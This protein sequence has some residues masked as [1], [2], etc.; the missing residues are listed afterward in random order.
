MITKI[1][2]ILFF[3]FLLSSNYLSAQNERIDSLI[4]TNSEVTI[5]VSRSSSIPYA[6]SEYYTSNDTCYLNVCYYDG[7]STVISNEITTIPLS[8]PTQSGNYL[9]KLTTS[10]TF[11]TNNC[12]DS[13]RFDS[14]TV[15]FSMPLTEPIILSNH[16]LLNESKVNIYPNPASDF[17]NFEL[18]PSVII[19]DIQLLDLNGKLIKVFE[20]ESRSLAVG[21]VAKGVYLLKLETEKGVVF[22]KIL[23]D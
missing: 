23:I 3:L 2:Q 6:N 22:E 17:I 21:C 15:N 12:D 10:F 19:E 1:H 5:H 11:D 20:K 13:I 9:F 18:K 16:E 14:V 8:L 4:I 7:Q